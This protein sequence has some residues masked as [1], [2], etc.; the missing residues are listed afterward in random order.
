MWLTLLA[1]GLRW[2]GYGS[3]YALLARRGTGPPAARP[4]QAAYA[5]TRAVYRAARRLPYATC[6][7]R[8]LTLW[9]LLRRQGVPS[10]LHVGVRR[11]SDTFAAH[12][13]VEYQG[14]ALGEGNAVRTRFAAFDRAL[15]GPKRDDPD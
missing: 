9:Y 6:L 7:P 14:R 5:T 12:A 3:L 15:T 4:N 10:D 8:S 13:W 2:R 11:E 1:V